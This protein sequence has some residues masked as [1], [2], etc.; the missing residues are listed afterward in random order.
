MCGRG[1]ARCQL[2]GMV[3]CA[4]AVAR[5]DAQSW[6]ILFFFG[7]PR[8]RLSHTSS[9]PSSLRCGHQTQ[10]KL[11]QVAATRARLDAALGLAAGRAA[12]DQI[13]AVIAAARDELGE[14]LD[15]KLGDSI[16]EHQIFDAHAR[17]FEREYVGSRRAACAAASAPGSLRTARIPIRGG[18]IAPTGASL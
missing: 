14:R 15:D 2:F 1:A 3:W 17:Q 18:H 11:E 16:T 13:A 6:W 9:H 4:V 7:V 8:T 10:L 5:R 12:G